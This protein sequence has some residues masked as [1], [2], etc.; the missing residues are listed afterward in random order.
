MDAQHEPEIKKVACIG[1]WHPVFVIKFEET[2]SCVCHS[3]HSLD[4]TA[5]GNMSLTRCDVAVNETM[6]L[7]PSLGNSALITQWQVSAQVNQ[8]RCILA[9]MSTER[10]QDSLERHEEVLLGEMSKAHAEFNQVG[11][12]QW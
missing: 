11:Q 7:S 4:G 1:T 8:V 12:S 6:A 9:C 5:D 10:S 2:V 3:G